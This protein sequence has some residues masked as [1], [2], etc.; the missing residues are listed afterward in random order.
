VAKESAFGLLKGL[1]LRKALAESGEEDRLAEKQHEKFYEKKAS[2]MKQAIVLNTSLKMG[3]GKIAAQCSHASVQAFLETKESVRNEWL[4]IGMEKVVL[5]VS[6][7]KE[8]VELYQKAKRRKLPCALIRD[9]GHT[10][11]PAGSITAVGIGP[12]KENE[13]D[14]ITGNLKLL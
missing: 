7:D 1:V 14:E 11:V 6:S 9:A 12:A 8:L 3:K 2:N 10:Q 13:I 5:K 4:S